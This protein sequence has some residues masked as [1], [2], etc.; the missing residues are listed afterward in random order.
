MDNLASAYL[1]LGLG[2]A[3]L[4]VLLVTMVTLIRSIKKW[5]EKSYGSEGVRNNLM[6]E[7]F[8]ILTDK[9]TNMAEAMRDEKKTLL[10]L[11]TGIQN[12]LLDIQ[13]RMARQEDQRLYA[14]N[15]KKD[16]VSN[17]DGH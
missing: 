13:R 15:K 8:D 16:S 4:F 5:G 12:T 14:L 3:A 6:C 9:V 1:Q 11:L 10:S 2:G 17:G 7:K